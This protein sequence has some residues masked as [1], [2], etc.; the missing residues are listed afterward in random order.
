MWL[1]GARAGTP[2]W[3]TPRQ[4]LARAAISSHPFATFGALRPAARAGRRPSS[5]A[6][7]PPRTSRRGRAPSPDTCRSATA[8]EAARQPTSPVTRSVARNP[9]QRRG[10]SS[11]R[12]AGRAAAADGSEAGS[13]LTRL[14]WARRGPESVP[15]PPAGDSATWRSGPPAAAMAQGEARAEADTGGRRHPLARQ[16]LRNPARGSPRPHVGGARG[17]HLAAPPA[18]AAAPLPGP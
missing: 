5:P 14:A 4:P 7:R 18:P 9:A 6:P 2:G 13:E 15:G 1:A 11:R 17:P 12:A 16:D 10:D 3:H 8:P